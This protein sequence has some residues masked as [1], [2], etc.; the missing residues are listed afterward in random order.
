[1]NLNADNRFKTGKQYVPSE[2]ANPSQ[3]L[4][5]AAMIASFGSVLEQ[6]T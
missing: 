5:Y 6:L 1:M 3:K 2:N 4:I